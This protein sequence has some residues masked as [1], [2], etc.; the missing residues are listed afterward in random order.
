ME[1]LIPKKEDYARIAEIYNQAHKPFEA[2]YSK[3]EKIAFAENNIETAE[4]IKETALSKKLICLKDV[5]EILGFAVFRKKN[6]ETVWV[7]SLY[8]DPKKQGSGYGVS[9]LIEIEKFA[10]ENHCK[11]VA[12]ETHR[13]AVWALNFYKKN[14][15]EIV[16]EKMA[17][18]PFN[19]IL[20]KP[21]VPNRPILAKVISEDQEYK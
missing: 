15:Y 7:N 13:N 4:S 10:K 17:E 20:D 12:L 14:G 16:N 2:I 18:F 21:P 8:V 1:I 6:D 19:K 3:E 5:E 11:V 9:L